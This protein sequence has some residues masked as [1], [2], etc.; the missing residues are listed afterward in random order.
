[1]WVLFF[2]GGGVLTRWGSCKGLYFYLMSKLVNLL[3]S[4]FVS[5]CNICRSAEKGGM[6]KHCYWARGGWSSILLVPQCKENGHAQ[7][8]LLGT[9]WASGGWGWYFAVLRHHHQSLNGRGGLGT[10]DDFTN[11]FLCFFSVLPYPLGLGKFQACLFP[12]VFFPPLPLSASSSS[13]FH[14]ALQCR[15]LKWSLLLSENRLRTQ[16][17]W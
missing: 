1:M 12:N 13:P 15:V 4:Q 8:A 5:W 11:S 9:Q 14:C 3:Q 10:T 2:W 17:Q 16:W 7:T 6:R